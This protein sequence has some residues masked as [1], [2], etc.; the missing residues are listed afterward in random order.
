MSPK[1]I[2]LMSIKHLSFEEVIRLFSNVPKVLGGSLNILDETKEFPAIDIY[3]TQE[4]VIVESELPGIHPQD[5]SVYIQGNELTI[6]GN[7][8]DQFAP[9]SEEVRF[10]CMERSFG[11]FKRVIKLPVPCNSNECS[12]TYK[13]G[14]L[15]IQLKKVVDKR[16]TKKEIKIDWV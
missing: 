7:K 5:V 8:T 16:G 4:S 12:A 14:V 3:E 15:I 11:N 10:L 1:K 2:N 13:K 9:D 6:E